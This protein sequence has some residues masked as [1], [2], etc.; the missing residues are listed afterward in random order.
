M[1]RSHL[2]TGRRRPLACWGC[3]R[4]HHPLHHPKQFPSS[5]PLL[6]HAAGADRRARGSRRRGLGERACGQVQEEDKQV[7][8]PRRSTSQHERPHR[9]DLTRR[10]SPHRAVSSCQWQV[11]RVTANAPLPTCPEAKII[12]LKSCL[13]YK[14]KLCSN[15][16]TISGHVHQPS[17]MDQIIDFRSQICAASPS[18]SSVRQKLT[19]SLTE[20]STFG[21]QLRMTNWCLGEKARWSVW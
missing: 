12:F 6:R 3:C 7:H 18:N 1:Y 2:V 11:T 5:T 21:I 20:E 4:S 10:Q 14:V 8:S 15:F 9:R 13:F 19:T 16:C 17:R